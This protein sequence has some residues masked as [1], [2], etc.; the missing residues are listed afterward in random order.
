MIK[1]SELRCC[2]KM[3]L[4]PSPGEL[5][6]MLEHGCEIIEKMMG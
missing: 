4:C 3:T 2:S 1:S 6:D 5:F